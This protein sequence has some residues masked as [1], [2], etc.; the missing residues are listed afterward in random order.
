MRVV[1]VRVVATMATATVATAARQEVA[2]AVVA[3]RLEAQEGNWV[4]VAAGMV[5]AEQVMLRR[6]PRG[7]AR[8]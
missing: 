4:V 2:E 5:V 1:A 8:S 3:R 6:P 7:M